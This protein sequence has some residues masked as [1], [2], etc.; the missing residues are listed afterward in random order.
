[1]SS[2]T[3][4][5]LEALNL[6]QPNLQLKLNGTVIYM[7]SMPDVVIDRLL[8]Q[9]AIWTLF[10]WHGPKIHLHWLDSVKVIINNSQFPTSWV[11]RSSPHGGC[12]MPNGGYQISIFCQFLHTQPSFWKENCSRI[13]NAVRNIDLPKHEVASCRYPLLCCMCNSW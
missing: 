8:P 13:E 3:Q 4:R 5:H 9:M 6:S 10:C 12:L 11:S 1:M 7:I 2:R